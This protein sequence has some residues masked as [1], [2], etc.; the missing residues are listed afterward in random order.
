MLAK[1][2]PLHK[3]LI[4]LTFL[5]LANWACSG[6]GDIVVTVTPTTVLANPES[7]QAVFPTIEPTATEVLANDTPSPEPTQQSVGKCVV[8]TANET[9]NL[10]PS[11]NTSGYPIEVLANGVQVTDL[12]GR[13][14]NEEGTWL[15]V[16]VG[17]NQGWI[18]G[19]YLGYC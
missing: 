6:M 2:R 15:Y 12:G 18:N 1:V 5:V 4:G 7:T 10:R 19:K 9:V 11:A 17:K 16:S 14:E 13:V 3:A 8:V